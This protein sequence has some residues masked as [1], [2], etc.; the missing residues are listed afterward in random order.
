[1]I[2]LK[3][4]LKKKGQTSWTITKVMANGKSK[5]EFENTR[6]WVLYSLKR[7]ENNNL[8]LKYYR[9]FAKALNV[10]LKQLLTDLGHLD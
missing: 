1:M 6:Q 4:H 8:T 7:D 2:T 5:H 3:E 10:S 9:L